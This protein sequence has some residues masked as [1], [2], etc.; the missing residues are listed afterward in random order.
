MLSLSFSSSSEMVLGLTDGQSLTTFIAR[1]P[2]ICSPVIFR[3]E[4]W[5]SFLLFFVK[6]L[7]YYFSSGKHF[8]SVILRFL[9][10]YVFTRRTSSFSAAFEIP[11]F[12]RSTFKQRK[13]IYEKD[14]AFLL[15]G[16][17][18]SQDWQAPKCL[19]IAKALNIN[20]K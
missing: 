10:F 6:H 3:T 15:S 2:M 20:L 7:I 1:P 9:L 13:P 8:G 12:A 19:P 11:P 4:R 5:L 17:A 18:P 16:W 14:G